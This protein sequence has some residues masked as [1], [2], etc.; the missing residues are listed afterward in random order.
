MVSPG[1]V[2]FLIPKIRGVG[3]R[4]ERLLFGGE[5]LKARASLFP[6][7]GWSQ[8]KPTERHLF[9]RVGRAWVLEGALFGVGS[10]GRPKGKTGSRKLI[11]SREPREQ[12]FKDQRRKKFTYCRGGL[13]CF[14][15]TLSGWLGGKPNGKPSF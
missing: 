2:P 9:L 4:Y 13:C 1:V 8:G 6:F 5:G 3:G 12:P 11:L 10:E 14:E 15:G 7:W